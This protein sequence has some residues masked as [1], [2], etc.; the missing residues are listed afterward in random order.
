MPELAIGEVARR[1]GVP[2]TTLRFYE[3]AGVLPRARRQNGRRVYDEELLRLVEVAVFAQSVGFSLD[4]IRRL[5]RGLEGRAGLKAQWQ[6]LARAKVEQLNQAIAKAQRM[7]SA[8]EAGLKCGCIRIEDC[9]A[10]IEEG[11]ASLR[12]RGNKSSARR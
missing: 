3:D 7:K 11:V 10:P 12:A 9:L 2:A 5:F 4:E 1:T 8:I 6:P